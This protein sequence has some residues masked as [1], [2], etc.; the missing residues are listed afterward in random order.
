MQTVL[1]SA[2]RAVRRL[3]A[4]GLLL[5]SSE[6]EARPTGEP[7]A[8][9]NC[10]EKKVGPTI[11]VTLSNEHPAPS[12]KIS[13]R[14]ALTANATDALRTG[15]YVTT[16]DVG[17]FTLVEPTATRLESPSQVVHSQP[18]V[19]VD[20]K[21]EF[22]VE[23]TAPAT[24]GVAQFT[25]WSVTGN[26][27]GTP[28]DDNYATVAPQIAFGCDG[29]YYYP[30][31]DMDGFGDLKRGKLSC[32][33]L[34]DMLTQG[35]DCDDTKMEFSPAATE[36]CNVLDDNCNGDRDEGLGCG[37]VYPDADGDSFG[38][39]NGASV[40]GVPGMGFAAKNTD[41]ND[42]QAAIFPGAPE[43]ANGIDDNCNGQVDEAA[44]VAPVPSSG[45]AGNPSQ[46]GSPPQ[47]SNRSNREQAAC[48]VI[49]GN[50]SSP[51]L[52]G[53]ALG[54]ALCAAARRRR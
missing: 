54:A 31:R 44:V 38:S 51:Q 7:Q 22:Q 35:G 9:T 23:W 49:P 32:T 3:G 11:N 12:E 41:C 21:A 48:S 53:L 39:P 5:A 30:D 36:I 24:P 6:A 2:Q 19:L 40:Y 47:S 27:N 28:A 45:A 37:L 34:A 18:K 29:I 8:C 17:A 15:F 46:G 14:V 16:N 26:M 52:A 33:P 13:L 25:I 1:A 42:T 43:I 20:K 50:P 4:L 10:H